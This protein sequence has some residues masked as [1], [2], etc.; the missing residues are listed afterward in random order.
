[1]SNI[2]IYTHGIIP[3]V[4][5]QLKKKNKLEKNCVWLSIGQIKGIKSQI[6]KIKSDVPCFV[7]LTL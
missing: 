3:S 2:F 7:D 6:L 4:Y 5:F 1:M